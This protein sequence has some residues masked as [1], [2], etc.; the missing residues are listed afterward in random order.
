MR[1]IPM[2]C[3]MSTLLAASYSP[4]ADACIN[5]I[6][7]TTFDAVRRIKAVEWLVERDQFWLA[8]MMIPVGRYGGGLGYIELT[9]GPKPSHVEHIEDEF[10]VHLVDAQ[11]LIDMRW[12][13][14]ERDVSR[15]KQWFS[16]RAER[17]QLPRFKAWL[18][19]AYIRGD[20][21]AAGLVILRD[22][23]K[24]DL[25]PDAHAYAMLAR[26]TDGAEQRSALARC[27]ARAAAKSV[28]PTTI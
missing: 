14:A 17:H 24:R 3:V 15:A 25:M 16:E 28:C 4:P 12:R 7:L 6:Q 22:L 9:D 21:A 8:D 23:E 1:F 13:G 19:E 10:D 2:C 11:L 18:A 27:Q 20:Q 5:P 26:V